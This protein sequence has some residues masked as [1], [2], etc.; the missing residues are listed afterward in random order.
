MQARLNTHSYLIPLALPFHTDQRL[1]H[2][3]LLD[4]LTQLVSSSRL[5]GVS[6]SDIASARDK[7]FC[8][9]QAVLHASYLECVLPPESGDSQKGACSTEGT[10]A[11]RDHIS[12]QGRV[13]VSC[14][15]T[16]G[17]PRVTVRP[18]HFYFAFIRVRLSS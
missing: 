1:R 18:W 16:R 8:P 12:P 13:A 17:L 6:D 4:G 15:L 3:S 11:R 5:R 2:R 7:P 14:C 9:R 10:R